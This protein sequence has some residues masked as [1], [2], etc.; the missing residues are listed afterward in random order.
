MDNLS[1]LTLQVRSGN[2]NDNSMITAD[3]IYNIDFSKYIILQ[4][5]IWG[6]TEFTLDFGKS[7]RYLYAIKWKKYIIS[8]AFRWN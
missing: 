3:S 6:D 8:S 4:I 1:T 7:K 2:Y 5:N